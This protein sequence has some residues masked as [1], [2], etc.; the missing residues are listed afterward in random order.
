MEVSMRLFA[1]NGFEST[2]VRD[3]AAAAQV[4]LALINYH[5]ESKEGLL[6][7]LIEQRAQMMQ[8]N[9][10]EIAADHE[11]SEPEKIKC[12]IDHYVEKLFSNHLFHRVVYQEIFLKNR[13][14]IHANTHDIF[15]EN[16]RLF[17]SIIKKGVKKGYFV[18]VD[19]DLCFSTLIG[20]IHQ[21]LLPVAMRQ[22]IFGKEKQQD[23]I[24]DDHF[25][26]RVAGH[27]YQLIGQN[28]LLNKPSTTDHVKETQ[29]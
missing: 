2:T 18:P 17:A 14:D 9:I 4:N 27:L 16:A 8:M 7:Q 3:I 28:L 29:Y 1:E 23:P 5:F 19:A 15:A 22:R 21:I 24:H 13:S 12:V 11:M 10:R 20:T 26:K 25:R 6:R